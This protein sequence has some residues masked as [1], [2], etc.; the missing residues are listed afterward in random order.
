LEGEEIMKDLV[1]LIIAKG[2]STSIDKLM[3]TLKTKCYSFFDQAD[4]NEYRA[5]D[6]L[7]K[8]KTTQD[9]ICRDESISES[10]KVFY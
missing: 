8:A 2:S 4:L 3:D 10:L 9:R 5:F 7:Q 1:R 6:H